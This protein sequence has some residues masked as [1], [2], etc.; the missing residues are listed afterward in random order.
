M[1]KES[2]DKTYKLIIE[3]IDKLNIPTEDKLELL[4]NLK[5]FLE[6]TKYEENINVLRKD[7][8]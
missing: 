1:Q 2:L 8:R 6:P 4:V 7:K 5:H 3:N